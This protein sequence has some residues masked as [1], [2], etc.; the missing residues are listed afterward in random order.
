LGLTCIIHVL[1]LVQGLS[2]FAH[3]WDIFI[4]NFVATVKE[5]KAQLY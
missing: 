2:K 3:N 5:S 4:C 1:E